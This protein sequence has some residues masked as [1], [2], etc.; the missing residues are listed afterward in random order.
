M[1]KK[2]KSFI[3]QHKKKLLCSF[4]GLASFTYHAF[5]PTLFFRQY[6][7][8]TDTVFES[9]LERKI[10]DDFKIDVEGD[11]DTTS[12]LYLHNFLQEINKERPELLDH[13]G[14][15][16]IIPESVSDLFFI[17]PF[18]RYGGRA[19]PVTNTIELRKPFTLGIV[20][21]EAAHTKYFETSS[22]DASSFNNLFKDNWYKD[23]HWYAPFQLFFSNSSIKWTDDTCTPKNGF[24]CPIGALSSHEN[25]AEYVDKFYLKDNYEFFKQLKNQNFPFDQAIKYLLENNFISQKQYDKALSVL[26]EN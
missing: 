10:E 15:I 7:W 1:F 16:V 14:K 3:K 5:D 11:D 6:Y 20:A 12:L 18:K 17:R 21:H 9:K 4:A 22:A 2:T 8:A 23:L 24:M 19:F 26:K 13:I 25:I